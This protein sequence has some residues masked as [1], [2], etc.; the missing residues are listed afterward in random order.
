[1][2]DQP[3]WLTVRSDGDTYRIDM[4]DFDRALLLIDGGPLRIHVHHKR[5]DDVVIPAY[6]T[7]E[8]GAV[9]EQIN[10]HRRNSGGGE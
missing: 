8:A 5:R 6:S 7:E 2:S 4:A 9:I 3:D 1:M 10:G